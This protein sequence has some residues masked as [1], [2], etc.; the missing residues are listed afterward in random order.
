MLSRLTCI[1]FILS[2]IPLYAQETTGGN[3]VP[4]KIKPTD[5]QRMCA[6][7]QKQQEKNKQKTG[8]LILPE[9]SWGNNPQEKQY[10]QEVER[11]LKLEIENVQGA[12]SDLTTKHAQL[13]KLYPRLENYQEIILED[14]PGAWRDGEYV[15]FKKV[16]SMHFN[17]KHD[18]ECV[19]LDSMTRNIYVPDL[20]TRKIIRLYYPNVQTME[21]ETKRQNYDLLETL[22]NTSPEIQLKAMRLLF[23]NLRTALYSMDMMIAAYYDLRNKKNSWQINL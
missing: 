8:D 6:N 7:L 20:W 22:E 3:S 23:L 15:S 14:V 19:I 21:L 18:L 11:L 2:I 10:R 1:I 16:I 5:S 13:I 9:T 4:A 17:D 12:V